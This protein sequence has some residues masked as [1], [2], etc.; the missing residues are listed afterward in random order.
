MSATL[1]WS[2]SSP[3]FS[4][5][6]IFSSLQSPQTKPLQSPLLPPP[7]P[8]YLSPT[9]TS[10]FRPSPPSRDRRALSGHKTGVPADPPPSRDFPQSPKLTPLQSPLLHPPILY[11]LSPI[12]T[13]HPRSSPIIFLLP[14]FFLIFPKLLQFLRPPISLH[15][16]IPFLPRP[17]SHTP[18]IPKPF[19]SSHW[20]V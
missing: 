12:F 17:L 8:S 2:N 14:W 6:T 15:P 11:F 5:R 9:F 13:L 4:P 1:T 20:P 10:H 16:I 18:S 3:S 19:S 7:I